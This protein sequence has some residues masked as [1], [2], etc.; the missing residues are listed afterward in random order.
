MNKRKHKICFITGTRAEYGLIKYLMHE[1][2]RSNNLI[3]QLIVTGSH[4]SKHHG[5][6]VDEIR[7]DNFRIDSEIYIDLNNDSNSSTCTSLSRLISKTSET[8]VK[9]KPDLI[10]L[11]G[12]RYELIGAA[13][14]AMIHRIPIAH[15]HGGEKTEGAFDEGI[16]HSITKL[17]HIHFVA[18]ETYRKRVIQLGESPDNVYNVGGLG[19][20][21]IKRTKILSKNI[22]EKELGIKFM[23]RNL[24]ITYHPVT[25]LPEN[26]SENEIRELIK[27]LSQL[28]DTLQIF[29]MPNADPGN[30]SMFRIINSYIKHNDCAVSFKSLGQLRYFSCLN[31]VDAV[32][33][34]SSSGLLEAPSFNIG[35]INIGD[36]QKGRLLA[37]SIINVR[38]DSELILKSIYKLY[39]SEFSQILKSNS[40]PNGDGNASEIIV[41]ILNNIRI[42]TLLKKKFFD[43]DFDLSKLRV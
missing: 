41:S 40:N 39:T 27:A 42:D 5:F 32:V 6:T 11:L 12:D 26:E 43:I 20:D 35:T 18:S 36:R 8:F 15:I 17:S 30:N 25:L 24:L 33:G 7:N 2:D 9:L 10:V 3:L 37:K 38:P 14:S 31:Q 16:R 28:K 29:T 22:L 19:V 23:K 21:A 4:L 13:L 34:N 1:V